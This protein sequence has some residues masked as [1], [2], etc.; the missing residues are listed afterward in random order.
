MLYTIYFEDKPLFLADENTQEIQHISVQPGT[1][2]VEYYNEQSLSVIISAIQKSENRRVIVHHKDSRELIEA[3]KKEFTLIVAAGGLIYTDNQ[4]L[5]LI[6]RKGKWDLPKGKVDNNQ[7][8]DDTALR[9]INEETGAENVT[10]KSPLIITYHTYHQNNE[11]ILKETHWFLM[12]CSHEQT[13]T[14]QKEEDIEK[15]EWVHKKALSRY[16]EN[17]HQ[18]VKDVLQEGLKKLPF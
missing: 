4:F 10:I 3:L 8:L 17:M 15:C 14:P 13:L 16:Y 5:L 11:A 9:E 6:F 2:V 7:P 12:H 18:S 1:V